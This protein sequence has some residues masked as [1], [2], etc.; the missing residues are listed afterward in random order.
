MSNIGQRIT[1]L[2]QHLGISQEKLAD[3]LSTGRSTVIRY[4][5]GQTFP[6]SE[7]IIKLCSLFHVSADYLLGLKDYE[8]DIPYISPSSDSKHPSSNKETNLDSIID[9]S[10]IPSLS[11][12]E[13][14]KEYI[15]K[16]IEAAFIRYHLK[17]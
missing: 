6:N 17:K 9:S 13:E 12:P 8:E 2:R 15:D 10:S 3:M 4:E 5:T 11:S 14:I 1:V 16:T 7:V